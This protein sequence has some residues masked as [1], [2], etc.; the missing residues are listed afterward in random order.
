MGSD[1]EAPVLNAALRNLVLMVAVRV[2]LLVRSLLFVNG[3]SLF[4][5][6]LSW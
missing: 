2:L 5:G 4:G 1:C 3:A 6:S